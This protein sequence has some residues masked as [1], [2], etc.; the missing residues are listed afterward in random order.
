MEGLI[1]SAMPN[2]TKISGYLLSLPERVL[3]SATAVA[4]GIVREI[5]DVALPASLRRTHLYRA[6]VDNTLRFLIERV[7]EVEGAYPNESQLAEDFITR[8]TAGNGIELA[9]IL[10]FRA[11]PVWVLAAL[12]DLTGAGRHLIR[13]ISES[14]KQQGLLDRNATFE[15]MDQ[16]LE[17]LEHTAGRMADTI[18][19]P[20][21]DVAGLKREWAEIREAAARIPPRSI[22]P[23][24][25]LE[26]QWG[27]LRDTADREKRTV[28]EVSALVSLS[29][30]RDL[31]QN[32]LWLS[33]CAQ[34][35]AKTTGN[36]MASNLL[37]HYGGA[38]RE[39]R[40]QG[41]FA[42]WMREFRPYL[43]AAAKQFSP[44]RRSL[45]QKLLGQ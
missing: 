43:Q 16:M 40:S 35:A 27:D 30:L 19:M 10:A 15:T 45:T 4:G 8:R 42:Y 37:D 28:F 13:E 2:K 14:W 21:L 18:N 12:A 38:I 39:I 25:V 34:G 26:T 29:A 41:Y 3:R 22:P 33:R 11:S 32:L 1:A 36:L 20:P 31:P 9:G 17:G 23:V 24:E 6:L 5:G 44:G 7:G